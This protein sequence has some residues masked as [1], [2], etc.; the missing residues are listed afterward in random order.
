MNLSLYIYLKF[1]NSTFLFVVDYS[2][3]KQMANV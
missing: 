3:N 2:I 1:Q